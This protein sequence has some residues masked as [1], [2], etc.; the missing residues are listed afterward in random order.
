MHGHTNPVLPEFTNFEQV[1]FDLTLQQMYIRHRFEDSVII[2]ESLLK[3]RK[4]Y[5]TSQCCS[6]GLL[7]AINKSKNVW[8]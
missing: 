8:I 6:T 3:L 1:L 7:R 2:N 5:D 4:N